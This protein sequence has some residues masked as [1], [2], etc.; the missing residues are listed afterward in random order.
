MNTRRFSLLVIAALVISQAACNLPTVRTA[1]AGTPLPA[2]NQ[3]LTALFSLTTQIAL[4]PSATLPPILTATPPESGGGIVP[5]LAAPT[6]APAATVTTAPPA[7]AVVPTVAITHLSP[8]P[9]ATRRPAAATAT[10]APL[11]RRTVFNAGFLASPPT[12][13]GDWTEWKSLTTEYPSNHVT[14]GSASWANEDDLSSSF[15]A[16]WDNNNLY[17]AVKVRDDAYVQ[18]AV[19][20]DLYLGD[21][22]E[23]LLDTKLQED[24]Y[25]N[26]LSADDFQLGLSPGRPSPNENK[27]AFLWFPSS[28]N[29]ARTNITMAAIKEAGVYRLEAAI[30]WN[31]FETTPAEGKRFGFMLS[32]SDNDTAG[33][34][35]QESMVSSSTGRRLTDPTTWG[36]LRLVK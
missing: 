12:I 8:D 17:I 1:P 36:E 28:V 32:I 3:T 19:G 35:L 4:T 23:I 21:S 18:N 20:E 5:T 25:Y 34:N 24:F 2:P 29:G 26:E 27:E 30:P 22:L 11:A 31:V 13:D 7:T 15:H 33:K 14:F 10:S 9:T 16:G 6:M